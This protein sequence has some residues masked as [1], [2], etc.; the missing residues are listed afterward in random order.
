MIDGLVGNT[1]QT[2]DSKTAGFLKR[3]IFESDDAK[4]AWRRF[5]S[6]HKVKADPVYS[7]KQP[8]TDYVLMA[9]S[10]KDWVIVYVMK[11]KQI[12]PYLKI[13]RLKTD[14]GTP[15]KVTIKRLAWDPTGAYAVFIHN[16]SLPSRPPFSS[17]YVHSFRFWPYR[18]P[19]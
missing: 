5:R 3:T 15:A 7:P 12:A 16:Q 11:G 18:A 14:K 1:Y 8:G 19:F 9:A 2:F 17:D 4:R 10:T 13:P 6:W